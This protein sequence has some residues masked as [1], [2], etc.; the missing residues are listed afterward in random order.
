MSSVPDH[1]SSS[2]IRPT[3]AGVAAPSGQADTQTNPTPPTVGSLAASLFPSQFPRVRATTDGSKYNRLLQLVKTA[4][5]HGLSTVA[6]SCD[7]MA[8]MTRALEALEK[9]VD[10]LANSN[11]NGLVKSLR[12][13]YR[14]PSVSGALLE[15]F[16]LFPKLPLEIRRMIWQKILFK[17]RTITADILIPPAGLKG[18]FSRPRAILT[19][20]YQESRA[21]ALRVQQQLNKGQIGSELVFMNAKV[22]IVW[23]SSLAISD[24][25]W[26][27][28]FDG[29]SRILLPKCIP[30][31]A[32]TLDVWTRLMCGGALRPRFLDAVAKFNTEEIVVVVGS[33]AAF[34]S[35]DLELIKPRQTAPRLLHTNFISRFGLPPVPDWVRIEKCMM[36]QIRQCQTINTHARK[37]LIQA[38]GNPDHPVHRGAYKDLSQWK[39]KKVR[40]MEAI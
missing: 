11:F 31:F 21:E 10:F 22:D 29:F 20:V 5:D 13:D 18:N 37:Q 35:P 12:I 33:C 15:S 17:A 25:E 8:L 40:F 9:K 28:V 16:T 6:V 19:A 2:A 30:K 38:G 24:C 36:F 1:D 27:A 26:V 32:L 4:Q 14:S 23:I 39:F 3:L 7:M 34:G